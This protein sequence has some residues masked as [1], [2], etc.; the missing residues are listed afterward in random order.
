M[1]NGVV[2]D[3]LAI[4]REF[5]QALTL[6]EFSHIRGSTDSE[7]MAATYIHHLT[8]GQGEASWEEE[9]TLDQM[10]AALTNTITDVLAAQIKLLPGTDISPSSLNL[11]VTDGVKLVAVR[12][13][14]HET[15]QPPSLYWS[16][17]AGTSLNSKYPG[18]P[19]T[20][21]TSANVTKSAEEHGVHVIVA[22]EPTTFH[23]KDWHLIKQNELI[24]VDTK[25][26]ISFAPCSADWQV[27]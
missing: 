5:S 19:E 4:K 18:H 10:A 6:K 22:S 27:R 23:S 8:K 11:A 9:F 26:V 3:F 21:E 25:G 16:N 17:T 15:E 20:D 7:Y 13:R 14:N 1:H 2:T 24:M 12:F